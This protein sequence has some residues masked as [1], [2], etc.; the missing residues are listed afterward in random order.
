MLRNIR[1]FEAGNVNRMIV[2]SD[3]GH[4][5]ACQQIE[6]VHQASK[7]RIEVLYLAVDAVKVFEA[8]EQAKKRIR[9]FVHRADSTGEGGSNLWWLHPHPTPEDAPGFLDRVLA[10]MKADGRIV[11]DGC[12]AKKEFQTEIDGLAPPPKAFAYHYWQLEPIRE[13]SR[14]KF[15][16]WIWKIHRDS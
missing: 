11:S 13:T 16:T 3:N 14:R 4:S 2:R 9:V 15:P 7:R 1:G 10:I 8:L 12:L 5:F 6:L